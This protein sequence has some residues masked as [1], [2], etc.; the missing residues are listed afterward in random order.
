MRVLFLLLM[1][2]AAPAWGQRVKSITVPDLHGKLVTFSV[3]SSPAMDNIAKADLAYNVILVNWERLL[4]LNPSPQLVQVVLAHE[5]GHLLQRDTS[6]QREALADY[7]AGRAM[8]IEGYTSR[9][10]A[11]VRGEML[12]ILGQGDATHP[13]A[14][15][16]VQIT[17]RGYNSVAAPVQSVARNNASIRPPNAVADSGGWRHFGQNSLR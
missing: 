14:A 4:R 17:M 1:T 12:R 8:R 6:A 9:D 11:I 2:L 5:A 13:P 3:W 7:F 16:R 10:M 15:E